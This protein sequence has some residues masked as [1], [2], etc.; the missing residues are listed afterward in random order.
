MINEKDIE[1]LILNNKDIIDFKD[2]KIIKDPMNNY[3]CN[4]SMADTVDVLYTNTDV[5]TLSIIFSFNTIEDLD[6]ILLNKNLPLKP[7]KSL[8]YPT[9]TKLLKEVIKLKQILK[10][11][12]N[13]FTY[14]LYFNFNENYELKGISSRLCYL[15]HNKIFDYSF[16][17]SFKENSI[18]DIVLNCYV[19]FDLILTEKI[20]PQDISFIEIF[21]T[22]FIFK[23]K[24]SGNTID[25]P[26]SDITIDNYF[27]YLNLI[28]LTEY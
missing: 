27:D 17:Y 25:F 2:F 24:I 28:E 6:N 26:I 7:F 18:S 11:E 19:L 16:I 8:L 23:T 21:K 15:I 14:F 4:L 22:F 10:D 5:I 13:D 1:N 20:K 9:L 3:S 12:E